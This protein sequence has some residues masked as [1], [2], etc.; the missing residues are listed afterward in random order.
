MISSIQNADTVAPLF[1][2]E[3][4]GMKNITRL[5]LVALLALPIAAQTSKPVVGRR[6]CVVAVRDSSLFTLCARRTC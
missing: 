6:I 4:S 3:P 5:I 1:D 2:A